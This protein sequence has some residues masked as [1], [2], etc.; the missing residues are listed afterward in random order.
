M[1]LYLLSVLLV[2]SSCYTQQKA[3]NQITKAKEKFPSVVS[4]K[5]AE[6]FPCKTIKVKSD[7]VKYKTVVR[8]LK[9][10]DTTYLMDTLF[11]LDTVLIEKNC[12]KVLYKYREILKEVPAVHDTIIRVDSSSLFTLTYE[13]DAA[14]LDK[15]K[16]ETKYKV[17]LKISFWLFL[18]LILAL[19]YASRKKLY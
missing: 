6:W 1:R 15:N 4:K 18:I 3:M 2:L 8:T 16:Y 10:I 14:L 5:A 19:L 9:S 13:R 7:S 17:F 11:R 12:T